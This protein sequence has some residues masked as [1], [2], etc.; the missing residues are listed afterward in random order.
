MGTDYYFIYF[1]IEDSKS[2]TL[3]FSSKNHVMLK[4][5]KKT[6]KKRWK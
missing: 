2:Y 4:M 5:R 6:N 3:K 1:Y